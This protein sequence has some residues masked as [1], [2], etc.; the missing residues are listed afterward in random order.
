MTPHTQFSWL[1]LTNVVDDD[2][3]F[4]EPP[5]LTMTRVKRNRTLP[6]NG[7]SGILALLNT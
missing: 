1:S 7:P 4:Q 2:L 6:A 3:I 5:M